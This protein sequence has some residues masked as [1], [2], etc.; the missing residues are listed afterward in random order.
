[1]EGGSSISCGIVLP[2]HDA[3]ETAEAAALAEGQG[4]DGVFVAESVWGVDAWIAL[5]AAALKTT[6]LRLGT[7]LTPIA[8]MK[9]WDLASR[10][11][12][13]DRLSGGRVQLSAGLGALHP[14]WTAFEPATS[15]KD[16]V[17]LLEEGLAVYDGLMRGQPFSFEGRHYRVQPT[18]FFVPPP[19]VQR[20]RVPVWVV[21]ASPS[22]KSLRRAA[23]WDGLI[24]NLVAEEGVRGLASPEE[25]RP[26]R[27][28]GRRHSQGVELYR[29]LRRRCRGNHRRKR[30]SLRER[31]SRSVE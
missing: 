3:G 16:R 25:L 12:T 7:M 26:R 4:W 31:R 28:R 13:L 8:R 21:G 20:P 15:R 1:L 29:P 11:G 23:S 19:P 14:G 18:D 30:S 24:P 10:V 17:E 5:T 9:P 6:R 2:F 27:R 22:Q